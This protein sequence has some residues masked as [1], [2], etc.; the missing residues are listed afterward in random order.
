MTRPLADV[1]EATPRKPGDVM[2]EQVRRYRE[3]RGWSQRGLCQIFADRFDVTIN[4]ATLARL[5][6]G[7]RR[8]TVDE[9][10]MFAVALDVPLLALMWPLTESEPVSPVPGV[11]T[12]PWRAME[13]TVGNDQLPGVATE[14]EPWNN[15]TGTIG[16][17]MWLLNTA[18]LA[19]VDRDSSP[20]EKYRETLRFLAG[21]L[22]EAD[23]IG[24][25]TKGMIPD[26]VLEDLEQAKAKAPMKQ[27]TIRQQRG[28]S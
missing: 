25:V 3:R 22:Y 11:Q 15:A 28:E 9:A 1:L 4:P 19:D 5:E 26:Q 18:E 12:E 27:R 23:E 6:T 8:I 24:L 10:A 2:A 17:V 14:A 20:K 7:K 21:H 13:W 16:L